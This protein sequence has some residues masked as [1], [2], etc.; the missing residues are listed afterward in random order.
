MGTSDRP[1]DAPET[2]PTAQIDAAFYLDGPLYYLGRV[3]PGVLEVVLLR[4]AEGRAA[5]LFRSRQKA[6][7]HLPRLPEGT[8]VH[9][10]AA[11][12]FRAKEELLRAA[13]VRGA[14][15]LW[16]DAD[17][18]EREAAERYPLPRALSYVLSFKRQSACL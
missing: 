1:V 13:L 12:D 18:N 14:G 10:L 6:H 5:L 9:T 4:T 17:V 2:Q 7:A 15:E 11:D 8:Q 16:L 3:L